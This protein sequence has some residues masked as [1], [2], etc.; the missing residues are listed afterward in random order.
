MQQSP[1]SVS[2]VKLLIF[3]SVFCL[4]GILTFLQYPPLSL[5]QRK[6]AELKAQKVPANQVAPPSARFHSVKIDPS[7]SF[8]VYSATAQ[9]LLL[10]ENA[11]RA[12][13]PLVIGGKH[14]EVL[15]VAVNPAN[16]DIL[17][18][19]RRDG[20]WKT[21]DGGRSWTPLPYPAS[22]PIAVAISNRQPDVLYM[23]TARQG[24]HKSTDG[25]YQWVEVSKGLPEARAGG[26]A[27]EIRS[28]LVHS[29]DPSFVLAAPSRAGIYR[30]VDGGGSWHEFN[31]G[32][33]FPMVR[34]IAS[35]KLVQDPDNPTDIYLA[36]NQPI[37]SQLTRTRLYLLSE[38]EEWHPVEAELPSN[39]TVLSLTADKARGVIQLWGSE[40]VWEIP[41][42]RGSRSKP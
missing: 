32:L 26:R 8:K 13:K 36:F 28:L 18:A 7:N 20:L 29:L 10:S 41:L 42:P 14:E 30:T 11:G 6:G 17:Y 23:A 22:V 34:P 16:A 9:G 24:V 25:G 2:R 5:A 39:F 37:H 4:D 15:S 31:Q 1:F 35:P 38:N 19:G 3:I 12:W 40:A 33:P 21:K 27:E